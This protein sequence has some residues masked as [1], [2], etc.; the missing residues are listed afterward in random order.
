MLA[1][2]G[3]QVSMTDL[4]G[5]A[6]ADLLE[7]VE[8]P[9]AYRPRAAA[10]VPPAPDGL[11]QLVVTAVRTRGQLHEQAPGYRLAQVQLQP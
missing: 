4:F 7:R 3:I 8:L 10:L 5:V 11:G 6:G 2:C 1:K 9:G